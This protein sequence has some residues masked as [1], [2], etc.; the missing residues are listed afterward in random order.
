MSERCVSAFGHGVSYRFTCVSLSPARRA[1]SRSGIALLVCSFATA[2]AL[3]GS[4]A[5]AE[6]AGSCAR[7]GP[8]AIR[9][10]AHSRVIAASREVLLYRTTRA[11]HYAAHHEYIPAVEL[12]WACHRGLRQSILI[13]VQEQVSDD[14]E[15][16]PETNFYGFRVAGPWLIAIR[17]DGLAQATVCG[18]YMGDPCPTIEERLVVVNLAHTTRRGE[19]L[20]SGEPAGWQ[21]GETVLS[22]EGAVAWVLAGEASSVYGCLAT[23]TAQG[24]V[25]CTVRQLAR[26]SIDSGS[27]RLTGTTARWT[28]HRRPHSA[29]IG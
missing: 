20:L 26:E 13:G 24:R 8:H 28:S 12:F 2:L 16:G 6:A 19:F 1:L 11:E 17:Q 23:V 18:K 22:A 25:T 10:V 9:G 21:Q 3:I 27:L 5:S 7:E 14:E 29:A 15:Y 4:C